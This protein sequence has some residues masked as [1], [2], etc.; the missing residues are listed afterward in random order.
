MKF[1]LA[2]KTI[3]IIEDY[4]VMRKSI[5]DMLY[6]LGAQYIFEAENS[7]AALSAMSKQKFDII[8]CDYNLGAGKNGQQILEEAK[9][10]KLI[11]FQTIFIVITA[12]Q[13]PDFVLSTIENKPDEYLAKPFNAQQLN[14]RIEKSYSRKQTFAFVEQE[15]EKGNL[16]RAVANCDQLINK[17]TQS[18][19]SQLFRLR[20]D[21]AIK[22]GDFDTATAIYEQTLE[23]REI[24]WARLGTGIIAY[25][26][27]DYEKAVLIFSEI[28]A[29]NP[30]SMEC[31]DWLAKS[32][33]ALDQ[34]SDA[35][36]ILLR[37]TEISPQSFLRQKK[38]A[39]LADKAGSLDIAEKAFEA[40]SELGQHS[41]HQSASDYSGLAKVYS[42]QQK[43]KEALQVLNDMNNQFEHQPEAELRS[44]SLETVIYQ[45]MGEI[46]L[47][48]QAFQK[49]PKIHHQLKDRTPKDL[50]IDVAKA[51]YLNNENEL[52]DEIVSV[53][54]HNHIDEDHVIDDIR[55]MQKEI[56]KENHSEE[57]I[58]Q[59]RQQLIDINNKGVELFQQGQIKEAYAIF[60]KAVKKMPHNKSII[61]NMAK[62]SIHN[63]KIAGITHENLLL[64]HR[65]VQK[66]KQIGVASDKLGSLKVE[67]ERV[68]QTPTAH[69]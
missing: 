7:S 55:L 62:I 46:D 61:Y 14:R 63:L 50:Q 24:L 56:G 6:T 22:T 25:Y 36:K 21:L 43:N 45:D 20:A 17:S 65:Y 13:T 41:V 67:F 37:A 64:A 40:V 23:Q 8:L 54:I 39:V 1:N 66:A 30:M 4:R 38:L 32:Y 49:V 12:H 27:N 26:Q 10:K 15:I 35:E 31:Y 68:T 44:A 69:L 48:E 47:S 53:L 51:C 11:S 57:I 28:I 58:H 5:K 18:I 3:L 19:R 52:A 34:L 2:S 16:A 59:T 42:K 60:E 33:E 9:Y 29:H